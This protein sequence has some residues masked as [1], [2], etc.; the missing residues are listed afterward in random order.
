[1]TM[2][3]LVHDDT[4]HSHCMV[5]DTCRRV[6]MRMPRHTSMQAAAL[7]YLASP[8]DAIPDAVPVFGLLDDAAVL[9]GVMGGVAATELVRYR[10]WIL[11]HGSGLGQG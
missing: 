3:R 11:E 4:L 8:I 10:A 2:R 9:C 1:M 6:S 7:A 5:A